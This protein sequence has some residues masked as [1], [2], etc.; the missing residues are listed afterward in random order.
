MKHFRH[1]V[2]VIFLAVSCVPYI[3]PKPKMLNTTTNYFETHKHG[4]IEV[5]SAIKVN[6]DTLKSLLVVPNDDYYYLMGKYLGYFDD[7]M[8]YNQLYDKILTLGDTLDLR[9]ARPD[10]LKLHRAAKLYK[11]FVIMN[12]PNLH[13]DKNNAWVAG[14]TV[15][16][17][18]RG[19]TIFQNKIYTKNAIQINNKKILLPL[20]N[21]FLVYLRKQK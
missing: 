15:Y 3:K 20:Y 9:M 1:F 16:D 4:R 13:Q 18:L 2:W 11:P 12:E 7:V 17:P 21:N 6:A 10:K 5:I 14:F 19:E 8:T